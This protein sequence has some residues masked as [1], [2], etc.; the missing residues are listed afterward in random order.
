M[1]GNWRVFFFG[2]ESWRE[3]FGCTFF[4]A[5]EPCGKTGDHLVWDHELKLKRR[6]LVHSQRPVQPKRGGLVRFERRELGERER[7]I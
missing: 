1:H 6:K 4:G 2:G 3:S 7:W 5:G